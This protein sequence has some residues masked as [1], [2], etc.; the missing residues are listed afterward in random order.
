MSHLSKLTSVKLPKVPVEVPAAKSQ[1]KPTRAIPTAPDLTELLGAFT[2]H[3]KTAS[4][5]RYFQ[6]QATAPKRVEELK[7]PPQRG[8]VLFIRQMHK[9]PS[10]GPAQR[11]KVGLYQSLILEQLEREKPQHVFI[12]S[13]YKDLKAADLDP[14]EVALVRTI[15]AKKP[16]LVDN[17]E[18]RQGLLYQY[19]AGF[20]YA[21]L[22]PEVQLHRTIEKEVSDH[23]DAA[24]EHNDPDTGELI[25]S[26][27]EELAT[28]QVMEFMRRH[29]SMRVVLI[30]GAAHE[31][32]DDFKGYKNHPTLTSLS[33]PQLLNNFM[34]QQIQ[35]AANRE[36]SD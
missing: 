14:G 19:G 22:H 31:F 29:P 12:E 27:R 10:F 17:Q 32:K 13:L 21:M 30:Y 1:D 18:L 20:I 35:S 23:I 7:A 25:L 33:F 6:F 34:N 24:I 11:N 8:H 2:E 3:K 36:G 16:G 4:F 5:T 26:T 9:R 28:E 15:F